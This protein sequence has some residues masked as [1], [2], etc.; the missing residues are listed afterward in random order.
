MAVLLVAAGCAGGAQELAD[1]PLFA[2]GWSGP[3]PHVMVQLA[4][5]GASAQAQQRCVQAMGRA[6]AVV[7]AAA[8]VQARVTL[9]PRGNRLQVT[10]TRRGVVRDEPR[11]AW[12]VERL[13]DDALL[14]M[15]SAIQQER[16]SAAAPA[17]PPPPR[18]PLPWTTTTARVPN[19]SPSGPAALPSQSGGGYNGPID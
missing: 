6:G 7:D 3:P 5:P 13:C 11:P 2:A 8:P 15:A 10:S 4:G 12:P 18:E 9:D 16:P 19:D 14:A 1:E 17:A